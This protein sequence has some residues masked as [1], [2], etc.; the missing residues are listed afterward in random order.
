MHYSLGIDIGT[1]TVKCVLFKE[2]PKVVAE[3]QAEHETL[4]DP[5]QRGM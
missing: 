1:S 3:S 2:G 5:D 4:I